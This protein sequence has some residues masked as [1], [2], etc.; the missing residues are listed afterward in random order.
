MGLTV[1]NEGALSVPPGV[2]V[3]LIATVDGDDVEVGTLTTLTRLFPG[4]SER[5]SGTLP[6]DVG[7]AAPPYGFR[8]IVDPD[9][10]INECGDDSNNVWDATAIDCYP[11]P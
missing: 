11:F 8:A 2:P 6:I 10:E 1:A 5:L 7:G 4:D 9:E 3:R